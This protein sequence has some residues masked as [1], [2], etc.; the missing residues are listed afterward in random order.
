MQIFSRFV[1]HQFHNYQ[2]LKNIFDS[3]EF[4][5]LILFHIIVM[6]FLSSRQETDMASM[7]TDNG[8]R[9]SYSKFSDVSVP[10]QQEESSLGTLGTSQ[11][12]KSSGVPTEA[13]VDFS[14]LTAQEMDHVSSGN[15]VKESSQDELR[16]IEMNKN[17]EVGVEMHPKKDS[18]RES[19]AVQLASASSSST[20][21][22]AVGVLSLTCVENVKEKTKEDESELVAN[23]DINGSLSDDSC[24][25]KNTPD[26]ES[27]RRNNMTG[28]SE[29][30]RDAQLI[31][32][33]ALHSVREPEITNT[34]NCSEVGKIHQN[35]CDLRLGT[36]EVAGFKLQEKKIGFGEIMDSPKDS[37]CLS[38][39][40]VSS[41][42]NENTEEATRNDESKLVRK[43]DVNEGQETGS[44][45]VKT[46]RSQSVGGNSLPSPHK[47]PLKMDDD[48]S[49]ADQESEQANVGIENL[50]CGREPSPSDSQEPNTL[51]CS[52]LSESKHS[53]CRR[54][55]PSCIFPTI[56]LKALETDPNP[57]KLNVD[58]NVELISTDKS[59]QTLPNLEIESFSTNDVV[60]LSKCNL[61]TLSPTAT[62]EQNAAVRNGQKTCLQSR[63][64]WPEK[65][66]PHMSREEEPGS[67]EDSSTAQTEHLGHVLSEMGPP[68]PRMLTPLR[69]PPKVGKSINPRQAIGKLS[70]P[71]PM[72]MSAS[73]AAPAQDPN[74]QQQSSS[75]LDSPV[76]PNGVPSSPLQFGSA[77]PKHAVPVP[78]RLPST[79]M[80]SSPLLSSSS[81][82][83]NSMRILDTMYP[84]LSAHARTLSILKGN[85]GLSI[86]SS[87]SGT[88]PAKSTSHMSGFKAINNMSTAFTK[89]ETKGEKRPSNSLPESRNNKCP[90]LDDCSPTVSCKQVPS[91]ASPNS[92]E[93]SVAPQA[94]S[95]KQPTNEST[96][97]ST[98]TGKPA[99]Q[100]L[101]VN[102]LTKIENQCFDLLPVIQ[103]HLYVGNLPKKPVLRS[104]EKEVIS[105]FCQSHLVSISGLILLFCQIYCL[106]HLLN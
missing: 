6:C 14:V 105:E 103:S 35:S 27:P 70:F 101:I 92:E 13:I 41:V 94:L 82:Q 77:T 88:L 96:S 60:Q 22:I 80:T 68:L 25:K 74:G 38:L 30:A 47:S 67:M 93:E 102:A 53:L 26:G 66:S 20:S 76:L 89:T 62:L 54:L 37:P 15:Q 43:E 7:E 106:F 39:N 10:L 99:D 24:T 81:S 95:L 61:G 58:A 3:T 64:S 91:S 34:D 52:T 73:P 87:E 46:Q 90:R 29:K 1:S 83:E 104:E 97:L 69:T 11:Y 48:G 9:E 2:Y 50:N 21:D 100:N 63:T 19:A 57:T 85:V 75:S 84:E 56:K 44:V 4:E 98:E 51:H 23:I 5:M 31:S 33:S 86:C 18:E 71:S 49:L 16:G 55:S 42:S 36:Q 28:T 8:E 78:G 12:P 32:S 17:S 72:D 45:D 79:A 40:N 65:Q 59:A